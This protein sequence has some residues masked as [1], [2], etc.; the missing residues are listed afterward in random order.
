[1]DIKIT[2]IIPDFLCAIVLSIIFFKATSHFYRNLLKKHT[3]VASKGF[4]SIINAEF[5]TQASTFKG[6]LYIPIVFVQC[7]YFIVAFLHI[8]EVTSVLDAIIIQCF[9]TFLFSFIVFID[10]MYLS[11]FKREFNL[12]NKTLS[13]FTY[14]KLL[15]ITY[16][17]IRNII[18]ITIMAELSLYVIWL[19]LFCIGGDTVIIN[20]YIF[21]LIIK[22]LVCA[23][24]AFS[25]AVNFCSYLDDIDFINK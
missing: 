19:F 1:M 10:N 24:E 25:F 14:K 15:I 4:F 7:L 21:C 2:I 8:L 13:V 20:V 23:I 5:L 16:I 18:I 17:V 3:I 22:F 12:N 9:L 6:K 11:L